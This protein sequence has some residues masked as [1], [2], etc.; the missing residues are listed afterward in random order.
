MICKSQLKCMQEV[1]SMNQGNLLSVGSFSW[2]HNCISTF[3]YCNCNV[4]NFCPCWCWMI[5]HAFQHICC[6]NN[7]FLHAV[8]PSN[9][10]FLFAREH[11]SYVNVTRFLGKRR[12]KD[13]ELVW[14]LTAFYLI[15]YGLC[16]S[17]Y[18]P[19]TDYLPCPQEYKSLK[20]S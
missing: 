15:C 16:T 1:R 11:G 8:T 4:R 20:M 5:N 10:V 2:K 13:D 19:N 3:S 17:W 9:D 12:Q 18:R 7:W 14:Q 6:Y